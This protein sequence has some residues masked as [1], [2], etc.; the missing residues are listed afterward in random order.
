VIIE[1]RTAYVAIGETA[2]DFDASGSNLRCTA[3]RATGTLNTGAGGTGK[4]SISLKRNAGTVYLRLFGY[5]DGDGLKNQSEYLPS[6]E[7]EV[8]LERMR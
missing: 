4:I 1:G 6:E 2:G 7:F 5:D 3:N 8:A